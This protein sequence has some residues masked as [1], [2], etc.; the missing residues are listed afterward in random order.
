MAP[1]ADAAYHMQADVCPIHVV[2]SEVPYYLP[3]VSN[4]AE[5]EDKK[6]RKD[7]K[8]EGKSWQYSALAILKVSNPTDIDV[9]NIKVK[10]THIEYLVR[11]TNFS[12]KSRTPYVPLLVRLPPDKNDA[13][14]LLQEIK[15]DTATNPP[16]K[17]EKRE[18]K[19]ALRRVDNKDGLKGR[20]T[21][22]YTRGGY[23][24]FHAKDLTPDEVRIALERRG[25]RTIAGDFIQRNI[26]FRR[27][28][29]I[30][31][32]CCLNTRPSPETLSFR[33]NPDCPILLHKGLV[34]L[35]LE[36]KA[37]KA[38][39]L[40]KRERDSLTAGA[41]GLPKDLIKIIV[42]FTDPIM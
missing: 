27:F 21:V 32:G 10:V 18:A 28:C 6:R 36:G 30:L 39:P 17:S 15:K 1:P 16:K 13:K 5:E 34:T 3:E 23:P 7:G 35:T 8:K 37:Q 41:G 26:P 2:P 25:V 38:C 19:L 14:M 11:P 22:T 29:A 20:T 12:L 40:C 31:W 33:H 24:V 4:D 42:E 9:P